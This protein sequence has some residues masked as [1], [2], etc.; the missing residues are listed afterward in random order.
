MGKTVV[1]DA[2]AAGVDGAIIVDQPIDTVTTVAA[3]AFEHDFAWVRLTAPTTSP[4]RIDEICRAASGF[5]YHVSGSGTT[6]GFSIDTEAALASYAMTKRATTLPVALGFGIR[7]AEQAK[8]FA[9][10]VD[11]I[12]VGTALVRTCAENTIDTEERIL[13]Q[14]SL[15]ASALPTTV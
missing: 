7:T 14:C 10:K 2:L 8:A 15:L 3:S 13:H 11:A 5:V 6:G 4:Q 1:V 12:V 9:G